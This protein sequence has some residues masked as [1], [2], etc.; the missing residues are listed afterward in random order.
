VN[1]ADVNYSACRGRGR[2]RKDQ[3]SRSGEDPDDVGAVADLA[4]EA[5]VPVTIEPSKDASEVMADLLMPFT[6]SQPANT[7]S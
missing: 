7:I 5:S 3:A 6:S 1:C 4:I 2:R